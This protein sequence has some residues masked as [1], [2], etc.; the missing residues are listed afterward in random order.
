VVSHIPRDRSTDLARDIL[1]SRLKAGAALYAY[2]SDEYLHDMG[3]PERY[4]RVIGDVRRMIEQ[5][6]G[7]LFGS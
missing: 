5:R 3:T 2:P 6:A 4:A 7:S 1:P